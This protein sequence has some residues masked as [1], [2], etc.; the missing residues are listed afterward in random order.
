MSA[1]PKVDNREDDDEVD[2]DYDP[3]AEV[4]GTNWKLL[5]LPEIPVVTG[6]E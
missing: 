2:E 1:D 5:D 3:E 4:V 6:E